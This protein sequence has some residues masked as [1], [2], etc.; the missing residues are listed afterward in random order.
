MGCSLAQTRP[1][2]EMSDT[3]AAIRAARE[4]Q[5]DVLAPELFRQSNEWFFKAR[6]AYKVKDFDEALQ[7]TEKARRYAEQAEFEAIRNGGNRTE[8]QMPDPMGN[9]ALPPPP[10]PPAASP[11]DN[12]DPR[13]PS[14]EEWEAQQNPP[15]EDQPAPETTPA[16]N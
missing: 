15:A 10:P 3:T 7:S 14:L 6:K 5:A 13:G 2:Q 4:V 12:Y 16:P 1:V 9:G 8:T 11:G